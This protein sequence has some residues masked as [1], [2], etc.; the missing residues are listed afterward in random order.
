MSDSFTHKSQS[1]CANGGDSS[2]ANAR[3]FEVLRDTF[4][5]L[6]PLIESLDFS[7]KPSSLLARDETIS[8]FSEKSE[9]RYF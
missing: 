4:N 7:V 2:R 1:T 6:H 3:R 9:E 5:R 8:L